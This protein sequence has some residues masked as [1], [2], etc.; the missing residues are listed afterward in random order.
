M[1][2][3][4]TVVVVVVVAD[5]SSRSGIVVVVVLL[6]FHFGLGRWWIFEL[7]WLYGKL[8]ESSQKTSKALW[9][10]SV[11]DLLTLDIESKEPNVCE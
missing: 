8:D 5:W 11:W 6:I 4:L 3:P 1:V 2:L 7:L 10:A 9:K